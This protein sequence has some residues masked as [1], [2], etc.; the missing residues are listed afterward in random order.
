MNQ[1]QPPAKRASTDAARILEWKFSKKAQTDGWE[2]TR[3]FEIRFRY[4][5]PEVKKESGAMND[6]IICC[7]EMFNNAIKKEDQFPVKIKMWRVGNT[8]YFRSHE[9]KPFKAPSRD[10]PVDLLVDSGRG[11]FLVD[12]ITGKNVYFNGSA[13]RSYFAYELLPD[14]SSRQDAL[15]EK[16]RAPDATILHEEIMA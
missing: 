8:L 12:Q 4:L 6:M 2:L 13:G 16:I 11:T 9:A 3:W 5:F 14:H 10:L 7:T 1:S 15:V